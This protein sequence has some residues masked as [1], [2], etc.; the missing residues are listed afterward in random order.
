M[1]EKEE[2]ERTK[3]KGD[4]NH[5]DDPRDG[6]RGKKMVDR[7]R[8]DKRGGEGGR[9]GGREGEHA[10]EGRTEEGMKTAWWGGSRRVL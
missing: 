10:R 3:R 1:R 5:D 2:E 7:E 9:E 8:K 4:S 6:G